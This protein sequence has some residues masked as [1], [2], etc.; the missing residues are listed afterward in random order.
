MS[1]WGYLETKPG[2]F[3]VFYLVVD[4]A[5]AKKVHEVVKVLDDLSDVSAIMQGEASRGDGSTAQ[6]ETHQA[7]GTVASTW[8]KCPAIWEL[9]APIID[10]GLASGQPLLLVRGR[11]ILGSSSII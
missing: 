9:P 1:R 11:G 8:M 4:G 7:L 3:H 10:S 5:S 2:Q 6:G